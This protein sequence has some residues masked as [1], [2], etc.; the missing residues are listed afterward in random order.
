M[1]GLETVNTKIKILLDI[2]SS[3]SSPGYQNVC[4]ANNLIKVCLCRIF[5]GKAVNQKPL[6]VGPI[7]PSKHVGLGTH[8]TIYQ[9]IETEI[10]LTQFINT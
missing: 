6:V 3:F 4:P 1:D 10:F 8:K 2:T 7:G 9:L 5:T